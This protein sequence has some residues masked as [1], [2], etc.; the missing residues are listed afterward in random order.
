M[1]QEVNSN[2]LE[3][4]RAPRFRIA[5][6]VKLEE[7]AGTTWDA[8]LSGIFFETDHSFAPGEQ[9]RLTL[10]LERVSPGRPVRLQCEG[11]VVRVTRCDG[12]VGMAVAI[13]VYK[14]APSSPQTQETQQS[15]ES[16]GLGRLVCK[17]Q[18]GGRP[19]ES[20]AELKSA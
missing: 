7:G 4:R 12:R 16:S 15:Q 13:S 6:P 17:V 8:S 2:Q 3:R 9:I 14:F 20:V 1:K 18:T 19:S 10:L 5:I 11:R